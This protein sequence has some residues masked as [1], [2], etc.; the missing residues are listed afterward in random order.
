LII[1][2]YQ[3]LGKFSCVYLNNLLNILLLR[4]FWLRLAWFINRHQR[5]KFVCIF[6]VFFKYAAAFLWP[7][8]NVLSSFR[9]VCFLFLSFSLILCC[10]FLFFAQI[11]LQTWADMQTLWG[12]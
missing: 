5:Q 3:L 1:S 9:G 12:L 8:A 7:V 10:I 6:N 11:S 4:V 2:I